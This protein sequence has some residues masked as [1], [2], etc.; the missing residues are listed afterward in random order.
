MRKTRFPLID[1]PAPAAWSVTPAAP[2]LAPAM[3][4]RI[5][6][7]GALAGALGAVV[8]AHDGRGLGLALYLLALA[9]GLAGCLR[10]DRRA[11]PL[12]VSALLGAA[13]GFALLLLWRESGMLT[14]ANTIAALFFLTLASAFAKP[15]STRALTNTRVRDLL[16][17][18][19]TGVIEAISGT[20]RFLF[21]DAR[22]AFVARDGTSMS[23]T[24]LAL[25]RA[26]AIGVALTVLFGML[27][28]G[29]DPVFRSL[30]QWPAWWNTLELPD[31]VVRF[32]LLACPAV[33]LMWSTTRASTA[34]TDILANGITLNRLD[35]IV[36]LVSLNGLFAAY[37][38]LQ[39]RVL[40][41]GS[42]YVLATTGLTLAEYARSGFFALTFAAGLVLTVLLGLNA[43]MRTERLGA[44][45]M[46]RRLST[47]LL[48]MVGLMLTSAATRMLLYV[49][50]FGMTIDR[51][52]AL[53]IMA[54]LAMTGLWFTLTVLRERTTRFVIGAVVSGCVTLAALNVINPEAIVV[55]SAVA[56]AATRGPFESAYVLRETG[57]DAVPALVAALRDGV[58]PTVAPAAVAPN[59][60]APAAV[61]PNA[62][63][64]ALAARAPACVVATHLLNA[65]GR[66]SAIPL[67]TWTI[68]AAHAAWTVARTRSLLESQCER[69]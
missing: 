39:L 54:W 2:R 20:P 34:P 33:A 25:T 1:A 22:A 38:L 7:G 37:L 60:V 11:L 27:L 6:G 9:A 55:R 63:A 21:G 51:I 48:V 16:A 14:V 29:G 4:R 17:L 32:G 43:L 8:F 40:F 52:V 44:W 12:R 59:A 58:L 56:R 57:S 47:S 3:A 64:P 41:G 67:A 18:V 13:A 31:Y 61:A 62:I 36:A 49:H 35:V 10:A 46:A 50:T 23:T 15:G 30:V 68:S 65:W 53:A 42:A 28:S 69:R 19:P 45:V 26:M 66:P 5:L 24:A